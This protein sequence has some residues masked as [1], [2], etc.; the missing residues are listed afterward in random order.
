MKKFLGFTPQQQYALL[1]RL[2]YKG[3]AQQ[4]DMD[5]FIHSSPKAASQMGVWAQAAQT[6]L[7]KQRLKDG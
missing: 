4:D 1:T 3:P 2:G 6:R 7:D 5:K